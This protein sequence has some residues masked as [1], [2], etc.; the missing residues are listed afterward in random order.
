VQLLFIDVPFIRPP[1]SA[2][3]QGYTIAFSA[4][5]PHS[6]GSVAIASADPDVPPRIDP[7]LL[8]DE[9]DMR[10]MLGG[11]QLAREIGEA[12]ALAEWRKEEARPGSAVRTEAQQRSY[13]RH[14]TGSYSHPVGTC[15]LGTVTDLELRVRG[16]DGLR[17]ADASVMP[18]IP[19]ANTNA[20]TLAI[21]ER[22][23]AIIAGRDR[24]GGAV[25][26]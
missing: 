13:L 20:P 4:L 10:T 25:A 17:V 24:L 22:A 1:E 2:P 19:G 6:R 3:A 14:S 8:T 7:G 12:Q 18:S 23:A 21:A 11:L 5:R 16:V 26:A 9:R 15:R